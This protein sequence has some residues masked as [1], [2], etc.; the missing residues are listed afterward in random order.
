M[1]ISKLKD[2]RQYCGIKF[3]VGV[4]TIIKYHAITIPRRNIPFSENCIKGIPKKARK[5]LHPSL[6]RHLDQGFSHF[7][8]N[9]NGCS[10]ILFY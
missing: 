2:M 5:T 3:K 8:G 1:N 7:P 4:V 10:S 6:I 9:E